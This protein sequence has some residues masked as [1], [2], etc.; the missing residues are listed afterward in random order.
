MCRLRLKDLLKADLS[1]NNIIKNSLPKEVG[2]DYIE[3]IKIQDDFYFLR[4]DFHLNHTIQ[5]EAKQNEKKFVI[6]FC[7]KGD[8]FY[9]NHD[10]QKINF[11]KGFTTISLFDKTEGFR[12][13]ET[14]E[15][16]QIRLILG[17]SFLKRNL[18]ESLIDKYFHIDNNLDVI[19]FN[20]SSL[21][22][23]IL[24]NDI[25]TCS[26]QGEL[27]SIYTQG[28]ALELLTLE[29]SKLDINKNE[30]FLDDYDKEAIYR[31]K[32]I[33]INNL[34]NPPSVIDLAK[35]VH[36][37]E[38]KLKKG[39][40]QVFNTS[41]YKLLY[42]YKMNKAKKLI[43]SNKYNINEIANLVGFKYASNFTNAFYKEFG[44]VPKKLMKTKKY[45]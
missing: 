11:K 20:P 10:K 42:K 21:Y 12:G 39:F 33:L 40:K 31:A 5:M 8:T 36:L 29:L 1:S 23:Q 26:L 41:P 13:F 3:N 34:K 35:Q 15:V 44:V 19:D 4:T 37:N 30:I 17:E 32:E 2:S 24:L 27:Y 16:K 7:L 28:K 38:F 22:S 9:Q 6:T 43:E 14:T 18:K 45:Y 25:L